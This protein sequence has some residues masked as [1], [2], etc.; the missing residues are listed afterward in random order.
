MLKESR[1]YTIPF[2]FLMLQNVWTFKINTID[3]HIHNFSPLNYYFYIIIIKHVTYIV[4]FTQ[5][6]NFINP[7]LYK[8]IIIK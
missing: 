2:D 8:P 4:I 1:F 3:S 7:L 6:L 5:I